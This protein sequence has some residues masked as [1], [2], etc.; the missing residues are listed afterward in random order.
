MG[1]KNYTEIFASCPCSMLK[2]PLQF[3]TLRSVSS[4]SSESL[5]DH[6]RQPGQTKLYRLLPR[7]FAFEMEPLEH[8][9]HSPLHDPTPYLPYYSATPAD[10]FQV[11]RHPFASESLICFGLDYVRAV[12][13]SACAF[14]LMHSTHQHSWITAAQQHPVVY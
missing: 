2:N 3:R 11:C 13:A 7:T 12:W 4:C 1:P 9:G 10:L 8:R 6:D 5:S 14:C